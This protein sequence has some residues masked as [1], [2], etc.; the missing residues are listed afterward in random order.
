MDALLKEADFAH[1]PWVRVNE[2]GGFIPR[3]AFDLGSPHDRRDFLNDRFIG[4]PLSLEAH[5]LKAYRELAEG[6]T[7]TPKGIYTDFYFAKKFVS[8]TALICRAGTRPTVL[9]FPR[10]NHPGWSTAQRL[11]ELVGWHARLAD[12]TQVAAIREGIYQSMALD[13][14][15]AQRQVRRFKQAF[16]LPLGALDSRNVARKT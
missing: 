11:G 14:I 8:K 10:G 5:T 16:A 12:P 15:S 2:D 7:E 1:A 4:L 9:Y 6:W 3:E 13:R